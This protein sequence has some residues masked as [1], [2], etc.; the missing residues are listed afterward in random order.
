MLTFDNI[1]V[2]SSIIIFF[3]HNQRHTEKCLYKRSRISY[4][5]SMQIVHIYFIYIKQL[6]MRTTSI[7][8]K[9]EHNINNVC[10]MF[11]LGITYISGSRVETNGPLVK[12]DCISNSVGYGKHK[13][14][15]SDTR[16]TIYVCF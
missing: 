12:L 2:S 14:G 7:K 13:L 4:V 15:E 5:S 6:L 8:D 3:A 10:A 11:K 16:T 9:C 1:S